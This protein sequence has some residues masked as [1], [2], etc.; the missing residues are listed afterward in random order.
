[1]GAA[2]LRLYHRIRKVILEGNT[3]DIFN[4]RY[5]FTGHSLDKGA[6]FTAEKEYK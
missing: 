6:F 5:A 1:M 2:R 4:T 3:G